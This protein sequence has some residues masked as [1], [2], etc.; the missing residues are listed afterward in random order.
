MGN[1]IGRDRKIVSFFSRLSQRKPE[2]VRLSPLK[3]LLYLESHQRYKRVSS[4]T[5]L[6]EEIGIRGYQAITE[7]YIWL[8]DHGC[9]APAPGIHAPAAE[10]RDPNE[11]VIT[12]LGKKF[13]KP[14]LATF[15]LEEVASITAAMS[16]LAFVLGASYDLFPM[17][18]SLSWILVLAD[19]LV[20]VAM[21]IVA[22]LAVR[23]GRIRYKDHISSL[24]DSVRDRG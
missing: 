18:P 23:A 17:S 4:T 20:G 15:S 2:K 11:L 16:F 5:K 3:V 6:G 10:I 12:P 1:L 9:I 14:Y 22:A 21:A 19:S 7:S 13:L 24:I 8:S